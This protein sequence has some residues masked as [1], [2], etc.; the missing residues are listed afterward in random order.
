MAKTIGINNV[1]LI[2]SN[3]GC[4]YNAQEQDESYDKINQ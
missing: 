2:N 4:D 3:I 1:S